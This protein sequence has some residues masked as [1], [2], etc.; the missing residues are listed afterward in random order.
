MRTSIRAISDARGPSRGFTLIELAL[1]L[2]IFGILLSFAAPRLLS[3]GEARLDASAR[4]L[5]STITYLY[6]ESALRGRV[7]RLRFDLDAGRY[8]VA[9]ETADERAGG[10]DGFVDAWDPVVRPTVLPD[11]VSFDEVLLPGGRVDF[12]TVDILFQPEGDTGAFAVRLA[13]SSGRRLAVRAEPVTTNVD[14]V[15][16][17]PGELS[18]R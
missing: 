6:D 7:Y 10:V 3:I 2:V 8:D 4:R 1:V 13:G 9:V 16:D 11:E 18:L 17:G 12:G 15:E 14:I 5:A